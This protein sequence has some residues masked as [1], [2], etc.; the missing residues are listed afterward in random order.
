MPGIPSA[1]E[2]SGLPHAELAEQLAEAY[3]VIADQAAVIEQL[4]QRVE[5]FERRTGRDSSNSSKPP[6][7]DSPYAKDKKKPRD[8]SLR[9]KGKRRP[10]KQ[11]NG[12]ALRA[13][14]V[15]LPFRG[16]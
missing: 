5:Q 6:S 14:V 2:L 4:R 10:G 9:E 12:L 13:M 3:R 15:P 16:A 11:P 7:S 1:E 8:R